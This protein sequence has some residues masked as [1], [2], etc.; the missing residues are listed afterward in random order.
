MFTEMKWQKNLR[1]QPY[2][3]WISSYMSTWSSII[4]SCSIFINLI[5]GFYYPFDR[6]LP[7]KIKCMWTINCTIK[8][9]SRLVH[10]QRLGEQ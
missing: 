3:S 5:V 10:Y 2:L 1:S 8:D 4:F 9:M 6:E 7:G